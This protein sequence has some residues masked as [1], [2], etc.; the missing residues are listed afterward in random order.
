MHTAGPASSSS[1]I[2]NNTSTAAL[3]DTSA[4]GVASIL[5]ESKSTP[6]LLPRTLK[7]TKQQASSQSS[8]SDQALISAIYNT[9]AIGL[10]VICLGLCALLFAVMQ[11]FIWSLLWAVLTSACLF[12]IKKFLTDLTRQRLELIEQSGSTLAVELIVLPLRLIDSAVDWTWSLMQ[13]RYKYFIALAFTLLFSNL[14][15]FFSYG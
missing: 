15:S 5:N 3:A 2:L 8:L 10:L 14:G 12:S 11:T 13:R 9:I 7:I 1:R 4:L 6:L